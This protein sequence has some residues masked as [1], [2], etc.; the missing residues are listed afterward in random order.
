MQGRTCSRSTETSG[1]ANGG[2][3]GSELDLAMRYLKSSTALREAL[4]VPNAA[5][6]EAV[7]LGHGEHNANYWFAHPETGKKYVLRINHVSQLGLES[8]IVY[9]YNALRI[10]EPSGRAPLLTTS[11]TAGRSPT[12]A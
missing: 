11:T 1:Y 3:M 8:Q 10:L 12:T 2:T 9:E 7:P 6:L 4:S 5:S